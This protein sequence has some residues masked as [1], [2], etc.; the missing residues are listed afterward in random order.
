VPQVPRYET[1]RRPEPLPSPRI[2]TD[3][4]A[5]AF[6]PDQ[7]LDPSGALKILAGLAERE[8]EKADQVAIMDADR[9]LSEFETERLYHPETGALNKKGRDALGLPDEVSTAWRE[10]ASEIEASLSSDQ[11]RLS[12][13][14]MA[15]Q[16]EMSVMRAV[17]QH[18]AGEIRSDD[19]VTTKAYLITERNAAIANFRDTDRVAQALAR[20]RAALQGFARRHNMPPE[21]LARRLEEIISQTH[22]GV[23]N[24]M[25]ANG[26]DLTAKRYYDLNKADVSGADSVEVEKTMLEGSTRGESQRVADR[27]LRK[28]G[29]L[30][31]ART[32][33]EAIADPRIRDAVE[34]RL[35]QAFSDRETQRDRNREDAYIAAANAVDANPD[36]RA[37]DVVAPHLWSQLDPGQRSSLESRARGAGDDADD[38]STWMSF[39]DLSTDQLGRL[40]KA[41]FETRYWNRLGR[42]HR[43]KA[44]EDWDSAREAVRTGRTDGRLKAAI[45]FNSRIENALRNNG[46]ISATRT[47]GQLNESQKR[48]YS[49]FEQ[50]VT[51]EIE[52]QEAR[53]GKPLAP[54][55]RQQVIDVMVLRRLFERRGFVELTEENLRTIARD[56]RGRSFVAYEDIP[57]EQRS[58]IEALIVGRGHR[59]TLSKVMRAYAQMLLNNREGFLGIVNER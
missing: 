4:P 11:Q 20:Q 27:L 40:S 8:R 24:R 18:V 53:T 21:E 30:A 33:L 22:V 46:L 51:N 38:S 50:T 28:H 44:S 54:L 34:Q 6:E 26:D 1:Q 17:Q 55:E 15:Q 49:E 48:L 13:R 58:E 41:E 32:D 42:S 7:P 9:R 2:S 43:E 31:A 16:R 14:R 52:S 39:L 23:I 36:R 56:Q 5:G 37:R 3:A 12:F 59:V 29:S 45:D 47:R 25:M 19:E 35:R 10:R 57:D